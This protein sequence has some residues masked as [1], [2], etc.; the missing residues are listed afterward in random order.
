MTEQLDPRLPVIVGVG[1]I[2][3]R[4]DRGEESLEPVALMIEALRRAELDSRGNGLLSGADAVRTVSQLTWRYHNAPALVAEAIGARPRE[5]ATSVMGGNLAGVM[6]ARAAAEIQRGEASIILLCG[7]EATRSM[8]R[9]RAAGERPDWTVQSEDTPAPAAIGDERPLVLLRFVLL[10]FV[11]SNNN[12]N[13]NN[14]LKIYNYNKFLNNSN[15]GKPDAI[16]M[17]E[18]FNLKSGKMYQEKM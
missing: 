2:T 14:K 4:P 11:I 1:Q 10:R 5:L 3:I 6:I 18:H 16:M 8:S 12:N 15:G 9:Y 13:N 7:G 17:T